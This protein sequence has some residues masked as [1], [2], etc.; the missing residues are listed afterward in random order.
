MF[1]KPP[2]LVSPISQDLTLLPGEIISCGT[3]LGAGTM[4]PGSS[5]EIIIDGVGRLSN[6]ME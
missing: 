2:R 1:F 6:T 5:I 3:S 4:K